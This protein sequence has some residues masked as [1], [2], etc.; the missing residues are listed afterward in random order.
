MRDRMPGGSLVHQGVAH[1]ERPM[2]LDH[3]LDLPV[4]SKL[5]ALWQELDQEEQSA[6]VSFWLLS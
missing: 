1:L 3:L 5:K 4:A 6:S 2:H